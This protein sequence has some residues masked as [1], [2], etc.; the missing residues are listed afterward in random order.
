MKHTLSCLIII[1][2]FNFSFGQEAYFSMGHNF[3]TYDY[4]NSEGESNDNIEGS[5]GSAYELGYVFSLGEKLGLA[6]GL[7]LNE[8][9]ATG[10]TMVSNYSWKTNYLGFQGVVKYAVFGESQANRSSWVSRRTGFGLN[11][12]AGANVNHIINGQQKINGQTFDLTNE[13][14]FKGVFVQP[15]LGLDARYYIL[16]VLALGVGY[17]YSKSFGLTNS[18]PQK[19]NFNNSQLQF[20]IIMS[21]N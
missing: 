8:F 16:N 6:T 7:T 20:N 12:N 2:A 21:L 5:S 1:A 3:T 17:H 15:L 18:T 13:V 11:F 14:E 4:T 19:L 10:G 9:N